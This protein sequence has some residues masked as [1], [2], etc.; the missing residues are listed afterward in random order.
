MTLISASKLFSLPEFDLQRVLDRSRE[1]LLTLRGQRIF[2][3]G[4]T[5]FFGKW[6][7][8]T[9]V[10]ANREFG[11][12]AEIVVLSRDPQRF[13]REMPHLAFC[14]EITYHQGDVCDFTFPNQKFA[15]VIHGATEASAALNECN[16]RRMFEVIVEG[17]RRTLEFSSRCG[18]ERFLL[19]S[20][21]A[22]Y[23]PQPQDTPFVAEDYRGGPDPLGVNSAYGEGKRVAEFLSTEAARR[24]G[25]S[26]SIARCFAFIGPYLPLDRHFAMGNFLRDALCGGPVVVRGAGRD[27][28]S[29]MYAADLAAW[30]WAILVT[31]ESC[32]AYNVGSAEAMSI[33]DSA[34]AVARLTGCSVHI[35]GDQERAII[36]PT[37]YVPSVDRASR[38]LGLTMEIQFESAISRTFDWLL[39]RNH[40]SRKYLV[41]LACA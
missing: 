13:L 16:P 10:A 32:R 4:G 28:R 33:A 40:T 36:T 15:H 2:V 7:L 39:V 20:S 34:K 1:A 18:A 9:F 5:G 3:T 26:V 22:I 38:E 37:H 29:Y 25:L 19:L 23:G 12:D 31:G 6:I 21:G 41:E 11:L 24:C 17:T 14:K 30:L 8:E 27:F 35:T